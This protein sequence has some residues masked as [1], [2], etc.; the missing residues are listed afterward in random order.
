V[1]WVSFLLDLDFLKIKAEGRHRI[2]IKLK[3]RKK[4]MML[5]LAFAN[6]TGSPVFIL[7]FSI[8]C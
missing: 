3:E 7:T 2:D 4:R 6:Q 1:Q 5:R 8:A